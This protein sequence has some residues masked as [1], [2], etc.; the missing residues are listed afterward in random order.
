MA[1]KEYNVLEV[2]DVLRRYLAGDSIRAIARSK[3]MDRNTVRKYLRLAEDKGF[4]VE[5]SGNLDELAYQ[6]FAAVHPEK[7]E[8]GEKKRDEILL[9]HE[10][11]INGWLE[12]EKLTLTKVHIKLIRIGVD[13]SY[14]A[15]WRFARERLGF[16]GAEITVRMADSEPGEVAEVDFGRLGIIYDPAS[17]RNRVLYALV[18]TLVFSRHQYVYT[19]HSQKLKEV[20]AGMEAAWESF[21]GVVRRVVVDNMKT[22]VVKADRYEPIF[23]KTFLEYSRHRGFIIDSTDVASPKQK[24]K[25]ERQV[26]Y[27]R[28]N[29]F[30]GEHFIDRD[31]AQRE[32][33]K[34]CLMT[35]GLRIHGT[36]RKRP[37]IVFEQQEKQ[38]LL[39]LV[40]GRFD[41]PQ[42]DPPH[43]VHP[44]HCIR[45]NSAGYSVPT[46][47]IGK[48]VDVRVDSKLVR[49][50]YKEQLIKIHPVMPA[51]ERSVDY[52]DYP[53]EK[54]AYA[55]RNCHYYIQ[56]A[57]EMGRY[58]GKFTEE[59]LSG[60]FP[61]SKLRQAQK[62]ISLGKKYGNDRVESACHRAV[63]HSLF[64]VY[65]VETI[66]KEAISS[67]PLFNEDSSS[68]ESATAPPARFRREAQYF[69]HPIRGEKT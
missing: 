31:H 54:T 37:R 28:E 18:V 3:E 22:A 51:G 41:V 11:M 53:K 64:N 12:N 44:D 52:E 15:L 66:I 55:M 4:S 29:F 57:R 32:A 67:L 9:P 21:E 13:V 33:E 7:P 65:R 34:W 19:T 8:P 60:D 61:W 5:F 68:G 17:G 1:H 49:I 30:K 27:V 46:D 48:E 14:S 69:K 45:V 39:P 58:C 10:Q 20:I 25:V 35:A 16:G 50:F 40:A 23:Q 47:Y 6:I 24:P 63:A 43:K 42:W 56:E 62:L 2:V 38:T 59:L 36:T 26:P